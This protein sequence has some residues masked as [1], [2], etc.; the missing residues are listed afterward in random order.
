VHDL[1]AG[2]SFDISSVGAISYAEADS[3]KLAGALPFSS[4]VITASIDGEAAA[5]VRRSFHEHYKRQ[6]VQSDCTGTRLT[7][8]RNAITNCRSLAAAASQAAASG[9]AAKLTEYFKSSTSS[10]RSTVAA[11]FARVAQE[12]SSSS[13]GVSRYYCS[14]VYGACS[15]GVLAYTLPSSSFMVNCPLFFSGLTALSRTCHAQD[16]ATTTLHE[17]THLSQIKGTSDYGTYG[18]NGVRSL[19]AAQNLNHAD[20]YTLFANGM[21]LQGSGFTLR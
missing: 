3:L 19:S 13:S 2:G 4:N 8:T 7:S 16:Q 6:I 11:V 9:A 17:T 15:S 20:T 12:C 18:Y 21:L 5:K 14:D 10:T 1:T